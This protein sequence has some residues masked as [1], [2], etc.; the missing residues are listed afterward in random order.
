MAAVPKGGARL[1]MGLSNDGGMLARDGD[2]RQ[3]GPDWLAK[4]RRLHAGHLPASAAGPAPR[5]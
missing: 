3:R 5:A 2:A 1:T 4:G